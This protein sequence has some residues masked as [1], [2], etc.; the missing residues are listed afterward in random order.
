MKESIYV[1]ET[2]IEAHETLRRPMEDLPFEIH[3]FYTA[4]EALEKI[5]QD[6]P[7]LV[8]LKRDIRG[9]MADGFMI[10]FSEKKLF[11]RSSVVLTISQIQDRDDILLF[12]SLGVSY[13]YGPHISDQETIEICR[14]FH[15]E[16]FSFLN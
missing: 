12:Q 2:N 14:K 5:D 6:L 7:F 13:F 11:N 9:M 3:S 10:A 15:K 8:F 16:H 4:E 1:I